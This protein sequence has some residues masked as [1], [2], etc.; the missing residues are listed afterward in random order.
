MGAETL[1]DQARER[2]FSWV[3]ATRLTYYD[4]DGELFVA[5]ID[6]TVVTTQ[7]YLPELR[8]AGGPLRMSAPYV[9]GR[10]VVEDSTDQRYVVDLGTDAWQAL[11]KYRYQS[12]SP[13]LNFIVS[14]DGPSDGTN[15]FLHALEGTKLLGPLDISGAGD[16]FVPANT[17]T[18][19]AASSLRFAATADGRVIVST[20][21][22]GA[23]DNA[24]IAGAYAAASGA[25]LTFSPDA[26]WL[27]IPTE[28]ELW[29]CDL[30]APG[31]F[32]AVKLGDL[33][34]STVWF[35]P[36][37]SA[38]AFVAA[39]SPATLTVVELGNPLEFSTRVFDGDS[40][41]RISPNSTWSNDGSYFLF[42]GTFR[43]ASEA[44]VEALYAFDVLDP[45]SPPRLI[46]ACDDFGGSEP[47]CPGA[48]YFQP[49]VA[50]PSAIQAP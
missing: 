24:E 36:N 44:E 33:S 13:E 1:I 22:A 43:D 27:A 5:D 28:A 37:S 4:A 46:A 20:L 21:V 10:A 32:Q 8:D 12:Y 11:P 31:A 39:N 45:A 16:L 41:Y 15:S 23:L 18:A 47:S 29:L 25:G 48:A 7:A 49:W 3:G 19:F 50:W 9:S 14:S 26:R 38:L 42:F 34:Q 35:A 30:G 6:D 17:T 40:A 2:Y